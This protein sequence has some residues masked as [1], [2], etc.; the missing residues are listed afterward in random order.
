VHTQNASY[1]DPIHAADADWNPSDFAAQLSRRARGLPLW[2]SLAVNGTDAYRG[3]IEAALTLAQQTAALVQS[4]PHLELVRPP[5][6]SIVLIRRVGWTPHDYQYW[7]D[8]LLAAQLAFVTP[9]RW[10]GETVARFCFVNP[11]TTMGMVEEILAT[12]A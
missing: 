3:A 5:G 11:N 1:L 4:T 2:F 9:T 8:R 6:L 7:S 10:E 12:A